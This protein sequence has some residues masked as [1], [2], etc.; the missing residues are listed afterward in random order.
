VHE[1]LGDMR[2]REYFYD[3]IVIECDR[4]RAAHSEFTVVAIRLP[5][6]GQ[7]ANNDLQIEE[8]LVLL[9]PSIRESDCLAILGP[10][11]IGILS[12]NTSGDQAAALTERVRSVL[13]TGDEATPRVRAGWAAYPAD[14]EETGALVAVARER[15]LGRRPLLA[16]TSPG[17][18]Q[19]YEVA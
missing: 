7:N 19:A 16:Q 15:M 3:R 13:E 11:E 8:A 1:G 2:A 17:A 12:L 5:D 18:E 4:A 14:A 10:L 6:D 9:Q